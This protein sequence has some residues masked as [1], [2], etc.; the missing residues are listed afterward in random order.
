MAN[1]TYTDAR[2]EAAVETAKKLMEYAKN[3]YL[4]FI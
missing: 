3:A 2:N 1:K 4:P